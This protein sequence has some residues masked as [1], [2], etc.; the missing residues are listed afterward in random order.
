MVVATD[1]GDDKEEIQIEEKTFKCGIVGFGFGGC[2][3]N[4]WASERER[5]KERERGC[6]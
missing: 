6:E 5:E 2:G 4:L 1:S 3:M